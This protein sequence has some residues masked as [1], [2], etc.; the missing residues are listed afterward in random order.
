MKRVVVTKEMVRFWHVLHREDD[1]TPYKPYCKLCSVLVKF[2]GRWGRISKHRSTIN[3]LAVGEEVYQVTY[4]NGH[5]ALY[6]IE[7]ID[8]PKDERM[9]MRVENIKRYDKDRW[10]ELDS[11][12][13]LHVRE[14]L[15]NTKIVK[16]I[17]RRFNCSRATAYR[18]L[19]A[20]SGKI[21]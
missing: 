9:R 18:K 2:K 11:F 1:W 3:Y 8:H 10:T 6:H 20:V 13:R 7:C 12:I 5:T 21:P 17:Q 19:D 15:P 16:L 4:A 14:G